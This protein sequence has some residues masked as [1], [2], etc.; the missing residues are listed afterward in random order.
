M[1]N[2]NISVRG[3]G[4][5]K[6][7]VERL[8]ALVKGEFGDD[9]TVY[10]TDNT[11]PESRADRFQAALGMVSDGRAEIES[12][13]DEL[14]EWFDNLSEGLQQTEKAQTLESSIGE[15]EDIIS[16]LEDAEGRDVEFPGMY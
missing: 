9:C 6:A 10:V 16:T 4:I 1:A 2:W 11:P 12:L 8:A 13:R 5:R 15:L 7:S 3:K 14:Q